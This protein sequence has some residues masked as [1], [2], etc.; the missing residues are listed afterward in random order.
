MNRQVELEHRVS[1]EYDGLTEYFDG[2]C[3]TPDSAI[4]EP[5]LENNIAMLSYADL[6][7][8]LFHDA[9]PEQYSHVRQDSL[10]R[11][12]YL[13]IHFADS[14]YSLAGLPSDRIQLSFGLDGESLN[15]V[16]ESIEST[17]EGY[18]Y[19]NPTVEAITDYMIPHIDPTGTCSSL[20]RTVTRLTLAQIQT[21][22][23]T[24]AAQLTVG[25]WDGT[26]SGI[27]AD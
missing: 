2:A 8:Q 22:I 11:A 19:Y 3:E 10:W 13:G 7:A 16:A 1:T 27:D 17:A 18:F 5:R 25:E 26:L 20:G 14:L 4:I 21:A 24:R 6:L 9:R 15:E 23:D 12:A